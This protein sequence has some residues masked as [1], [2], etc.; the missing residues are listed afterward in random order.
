MRASSS[1]GPRVGAVT[2]LGECSVGGLRGGG[3]DEV[4]GLW[5][6]DLVLVDQVT[7]KHIR[8]CRKSYDAAGV[9]KGFPDGS[10]GGG[11]RGRWKWWLV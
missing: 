11:Q 5:A 1:I 3:V 4:L 6:E 10:Q 7:R 8:F 2:T 9:K